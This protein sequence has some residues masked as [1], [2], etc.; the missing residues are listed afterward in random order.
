MLTLLSVLFLLGKGFHPISRLI[1][2]FYRYF[3]SPALKK[4]GCYIGFG[5]PVIP[6]FRLF[7]CLFVRAFVCSFVRHNFFV[8]AQYLQNPFIEFIQNLY[9]N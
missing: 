8:S 7:I 5:L 2:V 1:S 6:T 3:Y 4:G 9:V